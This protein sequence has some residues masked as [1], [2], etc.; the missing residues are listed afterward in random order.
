[1]SKK[2]DGN[3]FSVLNACWGKAFIKGEKRLLVYNPRL[4][5]MWLPLQ[6]KSKWLYL[7]N[8]HFPDGGKPQAIK[9]ASWVQFELCLRK[10][11]E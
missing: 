2:K 6:D 10:A 3:F 4:M 11:D 8:V 7:A 1:L 5:A 9:D